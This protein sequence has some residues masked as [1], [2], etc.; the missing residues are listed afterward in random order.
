MFRSTEVSESRCVC[1]LFHPATSRA[2][3]QHLTAPDL[4]FIL[5]VQLG[6]WSLQGWIEVAPYRQPFDPQVVR[7]ATFPRLPDFSASGKGSA[8]TQPVPYLACSS[9]SLGFEQIFKNALTGLNIG[10]G[11]GGSDVRPA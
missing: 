10:G 5:T 11:K 3:Y 1:S 2:F 6:S 8:L 7:L 9:T 4:I